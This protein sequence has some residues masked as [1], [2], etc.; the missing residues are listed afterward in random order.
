MSCGC[1]VISSSAG[2]L[3]DVCGAAAVLFDPSD[4]EALTAQLERIV[5]D[6]AVRRELTRRGF[7][8]CDRYSWELTAALVAA[9]Y[10]AA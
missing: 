9:A 5:D 10:H 8:N 7:A 1:P 2:A 3:P 6:G 4:A